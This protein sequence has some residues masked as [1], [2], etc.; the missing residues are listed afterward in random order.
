MTVACTR[1]EYF[2]PV[3]RKPV[4]FFAY[5]DQRLCIAY[6]DSKFPPLPKSEISSIYSSVAVQPGLCRT[7]SETPKPDFLLTRPIQC[8]H[9]HFVLVNYLEYRG[10]ILHTSYVIKRECNC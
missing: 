6:I 2:S 5:A 4:V 3:M 9:Q 10:C 7:L 1:I 8:R